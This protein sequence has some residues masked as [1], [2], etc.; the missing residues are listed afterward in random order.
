MNSF[1]KVI[2]DQEYT[3]LYIKDNIFCFKTDD[4]RVRDSN[5]DIAF[6]NPEITYHFLDRKFNIN[7]LNNEDFEK[8]KSLSKFCF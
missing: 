1:F 2:I 7:F 6:S 5:P 3:E 4:V 8:F